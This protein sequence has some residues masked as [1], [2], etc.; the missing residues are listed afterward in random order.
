MGGCCLEGCRRFLPG[1][2]QE[3]GS[4]EQKKLEVG[5]REGHVPKRVRRI[6][7]KKKE[8]PVSE[9]KRKLHRQIFYQKSFGMAKCIR[10]AKAQRKLLQAGC[11]AVQVA[12]LQPAKMKDRST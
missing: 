9:P 10:N 11:I 6:I 3:G 4:K 2:K 1:T 5:D 8:Q 12:V 7:E